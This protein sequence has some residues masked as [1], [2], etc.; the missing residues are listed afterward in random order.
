MIADDVVIASEMGEKN[1]EVE[2]DTL[3]NQRPRGVLDRKV[4]NGIQISGGEVMEMGD[5][6]PVVVVAFNFKFY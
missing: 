5:E 4:I 3:F 2:S 6:L 1:G